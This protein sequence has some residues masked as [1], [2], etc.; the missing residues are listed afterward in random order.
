[1]NSPTLRALLSAA[2]CH[3]VLGGV[4][5]G[6]GRERFAKHLRPGLASCIPPLKNNRLAWSGRTGP[7]AESLRP[8]I[9]SIV[10]GS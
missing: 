8:G 1:M 10:P 7:F 2:C 3:T 9:S 4:F 5:D 6:P